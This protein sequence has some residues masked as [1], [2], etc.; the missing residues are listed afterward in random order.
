MSYDNNIWFRSSG[1]RS[2]YTKL[3]SFKI[4]SSDSVDWPVS[5][6]PDQFR[7]EVSDTGELVCKYKDQHITMD[8]PDSCT[9]M[10][11][12]ML[13][14]LDN[15]EYYRL[16]FYYVD[17]M[18]WAKVYVQISYIND[19]C[20]R[21]SVMPPIISDIFRS[22]GKSC[23][24]NNSS[25]CDQKNIPNAV[26]LKSHD[27]LKDILSLNNIEPYCY[28]YNNISWMLGIETRV[29]KGEHYVECVKKGNLSYF[30][31][32]STTKSIGKLYFN[33]TGIIYDK[34]S[35]W[36]SGYYHKV[37]LMG[38]V[39][40]DD[41]GLG[42]TLSMTC[43][44]LADLQSDM[45]S[46]PVHKMTVVPKIAVPTGTIPTDAISTVPIPCVKVTV[47]PK[48][49]VTVKKKEPS[50]NT[51]VTNPDSNQV[52]ED[53]KSVAIKA[54]TKAGTK[55]KSKVDPEE[56]DDLDDTDS[57]AEEEVIRIKANSRA[58]LV[59]C[60][61]RLVGQWISE[62][63]KYTNSLKVAEMSTMVHVNKYTEED[64]E[65]NDVNVVVASFS[66][67][68]NKNYR[69]GNGFKLAAV[70]WRRVIVDEGHE[71]LLHKSKKNVADYRVSNGIFTI[72]C[73]FRWVCTGTP[74]PSGVDSLQAI[75]SYLAGYK[76]NQLTDIIENIN[77]K[78]T[79]SL[80]E[81]LFRK[82]TK[83]S[84][85]TYVSIPGLINHTD[86]LEFTKTERTIY[87]SVDE[88]NT[89]RKLQLCTNI[90]VSD[91]DS[92]IIGGMALNLDEVNK[93]M[94]SHHQKNI[95]TMESN[96]IKAEANILTLKDELAHVVDD[97]SE[98]IDE[99]TAKLKKQT[100]SPAEKSAVQEEIDYI[101]GEKNRA[102]T[103]I[104]NRIKTQEAHIDN[105]KIESEKSHRQ[106]QIFRSL[107]ASSLKS[108]KCPITGVPLSSGKVA[109]T[110][111]GYYYSV[112]GIDLLF[113]GRT[114]IRCPYTRTPL[115]NQDFYMVDPSSTV[116]EE[117]ELDR[118]RWGTKMAHLIRKLNSI[119]QQDPSNRVIIFSQ[120]MKMLMLVSYALRD[121]DIC[122]VF[123]KG[124]VHCMS[125]SIK[126]FKN[127]PAVRVILLSSDSCSSGSNLTEANHVILLDAVGSSVSQA[128][129][130]EEQAIGR[131]K[132][133]GQK[134]TVH[135]HRF[136]VRDTLEETY[137]NMLNIT[138][139]KLIE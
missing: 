100:L 50:T 83:E 33:A 65:N 80:L 108:Q 124:N 36:K 114:S 109:I 67:L 111:E 97:A 131:A 55:A 29:E 96:I 18:L 69:T 20:R 127:D 105:Y 27:S 21:Y 128:K 51:E 31:N 130:V 45:R 110:P 12:G 95:Y 126:K 75:L 99:L 4:C 92:N 17:K 79:F 46:K 61:R 64:F 117:V 88:N 3:V 26:N 104:K 41:V 119:F 38:G 66:L 6:S 98:A 19:L 112:D 87:D 68:E 107:T 85:K 118:S 74:M 56:M 120:W 11:Y 115:E 53:T 73:T 94:A 101:R 72:P 84:T 16:R 2:K 30:M 135:V 136:I 39:L 133:L 58:T 129:A 59:L 86:M 24:N 134:R 57:I 93:A 71:V 123:V 77:K 14:C 49:V 34:E 132:R 44:I 62:I 102:S 28:Q 35:L 60:P 22:I 15:N 63:K 43:L 52:K 54:S 82:N 9:E 116:E 90:N 40:C 139:E 48:I 122:Y 8:M 1:E 47:K 106:V 89:I 42:K 10:V 81:Y 125:N 13:R 7:F 70:K 37:P 113:S 91:A 76:H 121:S 137:Y 5:A 103:N 25:Y 23:V 138:T 32:K 78:D